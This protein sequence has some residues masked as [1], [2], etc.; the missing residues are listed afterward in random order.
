MKT[1]EELLY[2]YVPELESAVFYIGRNQ[3][4]IRS[5]EQT[6][7][8]YA[9]VV[10]VPVAQRSRRISE[11]IL[12]MQ[13]ICTAA[14]PDATVTVKN[15]GFDRLVGYVAGGGGYGIT[16]ISEDMNLLYKTASDIRDFLKTDPDVVTTKLDTD[17]DTSTMVIDMSQ[18]YLSSLG[19]TSYEA[20]I[21]SA[22]LFQGMDAGRFKD[23][24]GSR[25]DIRLFSDITDRDISADDIGNI[26][27][28]T[29]RGQNV[30]FANLSDVR[31]DR[32]ISQIN[33]SDRAKTITVS[34]TLVSENTAGVSA[35]VNA[36][37]EKHHLP[38]GVDSKAGG[39][40]SLI[41]DMLPPM[42]SAMLIAVFLVYA[43]M[44]IQFEKFRQPLIIMATIPF[45]FIGVVLGLMAFGSTMNLIAMLGIISLAGVVVNNGIILIDYT[46]QLRAQRRTEIA[47]KRGTQ[48]RDGSWVVSLSPD[49]EEQLLVS[50]VTDGSASR[51]RPILVTT[52]TT[53]LGDVPMAVSKGEGAEIYAPM[54]QAIAGGLATS[55]LIT[56]ILIPVMYYISEHRAALMRP[57]REKKR[58]E[59]EEQRRKKLE[60][61]NAEVRRL[62]AERGE[63]TD[64][65]DAGSADP[66]TEKGAAGAAP[67]EDNENGRK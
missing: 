10:L 18:E 66:D 63:K 61:F 57:I 33:H 39:I 37:L 11:I 22:I 36:Y 38:N 25:Y 34:A 8:A 46:N 27:I 19:L 12:Q 42:I 45:C 40:M 50:S 2:K 1:A 16:L 29:D 59:L 48:N 43:V 32:T 35:R 15:G 5:Q 67:G 30:S 53:L 6:N 20:G 28:V 49:E 55:T 9:H 62:R 3:G 60:A 24:S 4:S 47:K 51:I 17:F 56:L 44:V 23:A 31:V 65:D 13:E 14:I 26:H 58:A 52:L 7:S 54:G 64:D 21:T 41:G